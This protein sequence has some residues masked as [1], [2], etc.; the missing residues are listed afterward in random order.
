MLPIPRSFAEVTPEWLTAALRSAGYLHEHAVISL[1]IQSIGEHAGFASRVARIRFTVDPP[2]NGLPA[3]LIVKLAAETDDAARAD[4]LRE[5]YAR[6]AQFYSVVWPNI[7]ARTPACYF[8]AYQSEPSGIALLLQDLEGARFGDAALGWTREDAERVVDALASLH[9]TWWSDPRLE[10]WQWL[11]NVGDSTAQLQRLSERRP[12]F[13]DRFGDDVSPALQRLTER[14]SAAHSRLL[15][16]LGG[17]P[18]TLL[19]VDAHLDN[20]AFV[21]PAEQTEAVLFDWQGA[22]RGLG[23][24]DLALFLTGGSTEQRRTHERELIARYHQRLTERGVSGY[25]LPQ[26]LSDYRVALLRWCIGTINGLG[27]SY[28]ATWKNRQLQVARR[29]VQNWNAI[30]ADHG[31]HG[32]LDSV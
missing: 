25:S 30:H 1:E 16:R 23:V 4:L 15:S 19:H 24:L 26:L 28:A 8:V 5:K 27:S 2:A 17:K 18:T 12:V 10:Q 22:G 20:I 29:S 13:L 14:L 31:L 7:G 21:G 9:A 11:A 32:L 6:E 3:T